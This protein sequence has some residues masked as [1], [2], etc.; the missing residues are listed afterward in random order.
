MVAGGGASVIF[1]FVFKKYFK[2]FFLGILFVLW[3]VR[4][5]WLIMANIRATQVSHKPLNMPKLF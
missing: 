3:V 2:L 5:N 4:R 1:T